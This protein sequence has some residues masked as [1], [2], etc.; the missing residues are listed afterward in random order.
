M[1]INRYQVVTPWRG[2]HRHTIEVRWCFKN[3]R[4]HEWGFDHAS[5]A[6]LL[7]RE[8]ASTSTTYEFANEKDAIMFSL[9]F[10]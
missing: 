8:T 6:A 9:K 2:A 1:L 4:V 5:E 3:V 10:S 7:E